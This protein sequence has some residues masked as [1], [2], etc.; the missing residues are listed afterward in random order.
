MSC[1]RPVGDFFLWL[2]EEGKV[3]PIAFEA[4]FIDK[5]FQRIQIQ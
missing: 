1:S 4:K 3:S 2:A 5:G